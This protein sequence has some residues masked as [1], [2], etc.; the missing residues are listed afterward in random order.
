MINPYMWCYGNA[1]HEVW[2][3]YCWDNTTTNEF[4]GKGEA[5]YID[6]DSKMIPD[7]PRFVL[8]KYYT[9]NLADLLE[10]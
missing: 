7:N 1:K 5:K 9:P 2:L 10:K 8:R 4:V 6:M 3:R